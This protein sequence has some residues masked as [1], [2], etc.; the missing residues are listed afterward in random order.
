MKKT[1]CAILIWLGVLSVANA[2]ISI[3]AAIGVA[4]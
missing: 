4:K 1:G 2:A 3:R